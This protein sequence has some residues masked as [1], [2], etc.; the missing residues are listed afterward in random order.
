MSTIQPPNHPTGAGPARSTRRPFGVGRRIAL[1]AGALA[2]SAGLVV[3]CQSERIGGVRPT[4]APPTAGGADD[5][6]HDV[7]WVGQAHNRAMEALMRAG[8]AEQAAGTWGGVCAEVPRA[9]LDYLAGG[10]VR[11]PNGRTITVQLAGFDAASFTRFVN[12]MH[13]CTGPRGVGAGAR[14]VAVAGKGSGGGGGGAVHP[15]DL[16]MRDYLRFVAAEARAGVANAPANYY[17]DEP[18]SESTTQMLTTIDD[19]GVTA[20]S[21]IELT[22]R[23]API[24]QASLSIA[25]ASE[26]NIVRGAAVTLRDSWDYTLRTNFMR[27]QPNAPRFAVAPAFGPRPADE[28]RWLAGGDEDGLRRAARVVKADIRGCISGGLAGALRGGP[29]AALSGCVASGVGGSFAEIMVPSH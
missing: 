4:T 18:L 25:D 2:L 12:V 8:F 10:A 23:L 27:A 13:G 24:E 6:L 14:S 7:A 19:I 11:D 17:G 22:E 21:W 29:V 9:T 15:L 20:R 16:S 1:A 3:A 26:R 5:P 28:P